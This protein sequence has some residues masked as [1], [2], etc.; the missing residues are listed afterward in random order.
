MKQLKYF[1]KYNIQREDLNIKS[2]LVF[3]ITDRYYSIYSFEEYMT[4]K[5][6]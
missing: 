4:L 3:Y 2:A 6:W 1:E 5:L